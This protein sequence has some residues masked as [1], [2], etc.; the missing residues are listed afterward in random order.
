MNHILMNILREELVWIRIGVDIMLD[1]LKNV[2]IDE[3]TIKLM[4]INYDDT[5]KFNLQMNAENCMGIILFMKKIGIK[6]IDE[7]LIN[8]PEWFLKT[9]KDVINI[10]STKKDIINR[11]NENYLEVDL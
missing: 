3:Q 6:N 11:I 5:M 1:F 7:L 2:N 10:F 8:K 9:T 4:N